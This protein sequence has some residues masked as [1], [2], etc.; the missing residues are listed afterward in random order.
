MLS[1]AAAHKKLKHPAMAADHSLPCEKDDSEE[2]F[3][4]QDNFP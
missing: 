2:S 4:G 1:S 3:A